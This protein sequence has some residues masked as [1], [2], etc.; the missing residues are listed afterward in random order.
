MRSLPTSWLRR[1]AWEDQRCEC[2]CMEANCDRSV[3]HFV[4]AD[5]RLMR[6]QHMLIHN[7]DF[8]VYSDEVQYIFIYTEVQHTFSMHLF[9]LLRM[10]ITQAG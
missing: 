7:S 9:F 2:R 5:V 10:R 1:R 8:W 6:R 3:G 4:R